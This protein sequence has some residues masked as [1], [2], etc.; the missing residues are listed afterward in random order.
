MTVG[1]VVGQDDWSLRPDSQR[2]ARERAYE[3]LH[4]AV[5]RLGVVM[6]GAITEQVMDNQRRGV[7]LVLTVPTHEVDAG[8]SAETAKALAT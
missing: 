2:L 5:G 4:R 1:I 6:A 8:G 7:Q 3:A